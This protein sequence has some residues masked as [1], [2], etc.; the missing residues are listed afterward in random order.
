MADYIKYI[1]KNQIGRWLHILPKSKGEIGLE[2]HPR[3]FIW[4]IETGP[5]NLLTIRIEDTSSRVSVP[6]DGKMHVAIIPDQTY[7]QY[8]TPTEDDCRRVIR[9][10][11]KEGW[12]G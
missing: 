8:Y 10:A 2:H 7:I 4:G 12:L 1:G 6:K 11:F 3:F 9:A 5:D